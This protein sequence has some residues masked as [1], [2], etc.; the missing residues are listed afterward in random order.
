MHPAG[1]KTALVSAS[2][3]LT[4]LQLTSRERVSEIKEEY[5]LVQ[6]IENLR[7]MTIPLDHDEVVRRLGEARAG[8]PQGIPSQGDAILRELVHLGVLR[9]RDDGQVDVP[10]IYR[11]SFE[12]APDYEEAWEG[13]LA[14]DDASAQQQFERELPRLKEILRRGGNAGQWFGIADEDIKRGD[15]DSA[16]KRCERA[17]ELARNADERSGEAQIWWVLGWI[18]LQQDDARRAREEFQRALEIKKRADDKFLEASILWW[19][20]YAHERLGNFRD[21]RKCYNEAIRLYRDMHDL[22]AEASCERRL[23]L[24]EQRRG[25]AS[26]AIRHFVEALSL[27]QALPEDDD[28]ETNELLTFWCMTNLAERL[29]K[30]REALPLAAL[31]V[32]LASGDPDS[33]N[34]LFAMYDQLATH[35]EYTPEQRAELRREVELAYARDRGWGYVREAFP[36]QVDALNR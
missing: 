21:A 36:D 24:I 8:E 22:R 33:A 30:R 7:G 12:I 3:L 28:D 1:R 23:G 17:L 29:G 10:D 9:L 34:A 14:G 11:Y 26:M 13:F 16:R 20:G 25:R 27:A 15:Y 4:A 35:L 32:Y 6:R 5:E 19:L 31:G 2:D 18:S